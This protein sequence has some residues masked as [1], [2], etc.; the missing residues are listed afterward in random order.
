KQEKVSIILIAHRPSLLTGV[1][2]LLIL[3]G[4][5]V[6]KFGPMVHVMPHLIPAASIGAVP[7]ARTA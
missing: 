7:L 6:A 2:K 3:A 1:D 4:G 5:Q